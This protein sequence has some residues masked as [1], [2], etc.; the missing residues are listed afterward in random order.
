MKCN[1]MVLVL[2]SSILRQRLELLEA[3]LTNHYPSLLPYIV[4]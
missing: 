1:A 2:R 4:G 3:L